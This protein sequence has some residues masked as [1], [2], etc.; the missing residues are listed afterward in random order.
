MLLHFS[1][2]ALSSKTA[3]EDEVARMVTTA[4]DVFYHATDPALDSRP[5]E[6][7]AALRAIAFGDSDIDSAWHHK[8]V[9]SNVTRLVR[10]NGV[11]NLQEL[12]VRLGLALNSDRVINRRS[13]QRGEDEDAHGAVLRMVRKAEACDFEV[14]V[15]EEAAVAALL[16]AV[17]EKEL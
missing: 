17:G 4:P 13:E 14:A 1:T 10:R 8:R 5:L 15:E 2:C 7:G 3:R 16:V 6:G 11:D 9:G 12:F